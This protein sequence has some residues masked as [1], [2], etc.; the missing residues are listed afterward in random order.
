MSGRNSSQLQKHAKAQATHC[1]PWYGCKK[2]GCLRAL[3]L[4]MN[5]TE[6]KTSKSQTKLDPR[7]VTYKYPKAVQKAGKA[8]QQSC[9]WRRARL[10]VAGSW[11]RQAQ[12]S[13][14]AGSPHPAST[15]S[16]PLIG[17]LDWFFPLLRIPS[18]PRVFLGKPIIVQEKN[19]FSSRGST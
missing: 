18:F 8:H 14:M 11:I 13:T 10:D 9:R 15:I 3:N 6:S 17:G 1:N 5:R 16:F 19:S 12:A 4:N 7:T 2:L